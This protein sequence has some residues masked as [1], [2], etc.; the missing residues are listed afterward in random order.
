MVEIIQAYMLEQYKCCHCKTPN[1][2]MFWHLDDWDGNN[3]LR[4]ERSLNVLMLQENSKWWCFIGQLLIKLFLFCQLVTCC[5]TE[6]CTHT[7]THKNTRTQTRTHTH[8]HTG[9]KDITFLTRCIVSVIHDLS[10]SN[11]IMESLVRSLMGLG[12]LYE[13]PRATHNLDHLPLF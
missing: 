2:W 3:S 9:E 1:Y 5:A 7:H 10:P 4:L 12:K 11:G 6:R 8:T 13:C